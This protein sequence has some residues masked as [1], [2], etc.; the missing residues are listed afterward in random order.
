MLYNMMDKKVD[1]YIEKIIE[2]KWWIEKLYWIPT[3]IIWFN[4]FWRKLA[5]ELEKYVTSKEIC[6][7][8]EKIKKDDKYHYLNFWD[9]LKK[10]EL[11]IFTYELPLEY[12]VNISGL[13]P[14][15]CLVVDWKY[16]SIIN[17]LTKNWFSN[18]III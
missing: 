8:D 7:F 3:D 15:V 1:L 5:N 16:S 11:M 10:S 4:D 18:I 17:V 9:M 2:A 13:N 14:N 12:F 6:F